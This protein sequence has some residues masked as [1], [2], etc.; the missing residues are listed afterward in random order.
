MTSPEDD[1]LEERLRR[2]LSEAA[3]EVE[4]GSDG[5]DK[6]RARIGGRRPRPRLFSVLFGVVGW[7]RNWTWRGHWAWQDSLPG[8]GA[9]REWRSRRSN[10]PRWDIRWLL[11]LPQRI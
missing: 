1:N 10:F 6:I 4:P 7:A 11:L 5:L 2:A 3:G 9:L 8:L